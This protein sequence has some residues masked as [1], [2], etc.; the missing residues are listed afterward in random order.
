LQN[1]KTCVPGYQKKQEAGFFVILVAC[2]RVAHILRSRLTAFLETIFHSDT[3][4]EENLGLDRVGIGL[5]EPKAS[6][7]LGLP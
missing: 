3:S 1:Q 2:L 6:S 7:S 4:S 5:S